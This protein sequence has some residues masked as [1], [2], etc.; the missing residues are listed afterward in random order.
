MLV[1]TTDYDVSGNMPG[2]SVDMSLS[3]DSL[4]HIMDIL[5]DLYSNRPA[6]IVREYTTNALDA[7]IISG[8][9][10]PV[11]I[12]TP[13]RLNPNLVIRDYGMGM[14][15]QVLIDTYSKY[16]ASTKR[17]N[18]LE[19]GQLGLGSKSG[20]AYTDQFTVRSVHDGHC[21]ELIMSRNDRGAAEMTIAFDYETMD[22]S[23][24]TITIP[25]KTY[26]VDAVKAEVESFS[27]YAKPGTIAVNG[28]LNSMPS[29]WEKLAENVYVVEEHAANKIV[30]GN[31]AYPAK[32]FDSVYSGYG[33][34]R[35]PKS[36]ICFVEMGEVDFVPSREDLK[37]TPHTNRTISSIESYIR[38]SITQV[39]QSAVEEAETWKEKM[40]AYLLATKWAEHVGT[41]SVTGIEREI[42]DRLKD[43][44]YFSVSL[45]HNIN[46]PNDKLRNSV[47]YGGKYSLSIREAV[48]LT[49]R[50]DIAV[51]D[52]AGE[53]MSRDQARKLLEV[54]D[55]IAGKHIRL[56]ECSK[57]NLEELLPD[58]T[59]ISWNDAKKVRVAKPAARP[60]AATKKG[61]RYKAYM[62]HDRYAATTKMTKV[63]G[64]SFYCSEKEFG[65]IS[66]RDM[67]R[68]DYKLFMIIPSKQAAFAAKNPDAKSL[69]EYVS[70]RRK[71][72]RRHIE[73]SA[74]VAESIPYA[75]QKYELAQFDFKLIENEE[76]L[77]RLR[78]AHT[79]QKWVSLTGQYFYDS[80]KFQD[81]LTTNYPLAYGGGMSRGDNY[82]EHLAMYINLIGEKNVNA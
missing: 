27:K 64:R 33:Y 50:Q 62:I 66:R 76:F 36:F 69:V 47:G 3:G 14:S 40:Q 59:I 28:V 11:E 41:L 43:V 4:A 67:P 55:E 65:N 49:D 53:K 60:K 48:T 6:A 9:T 32:M 82:K 13:N 12:T 7:H 79:G 77:K 46:N 42:A 58:W 20:F 34:G 1:Q 19:A 17:N 74:Y 80:R 61:D 21:C 56:F 51:T 25:I 2:E 57:E 54:D 24:L 18:N 5:S 15:K 70:Q 31:V 39:V 45:P 16:G 29:H 78:M 38:D 10:K 73:S 44:T 22:D 26:D 71:Q 75:R 35:S 30:M 52:F 81:Y 68:G 72:L 63:T 37:Y 23:G 8:Q